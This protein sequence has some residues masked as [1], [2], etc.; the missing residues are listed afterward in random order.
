MNSVK[1]AQQ[2]KCD[3]EDKLKMITAVKYIISE[4]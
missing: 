1:R 4:R 2:S 3:E